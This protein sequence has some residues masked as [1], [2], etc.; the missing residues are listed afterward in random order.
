MYTLG[1]GFDDRLG[2]DNTLIL[3]ND[4]DVIFYVITWGADEETDGMRSVN[5][6]KKGKLIES[7]TASQI[8][9]CDK[10]KERCNFVYSNYDE[11]VDRKKSN[12]GTKNYKKVLKDGVDEKERFLSDFALFSFDDFVYLTDYKKRTHTFDLRDG[13]LV[14]SDSFDNVF[15]RIKT[16]GRVTKSEVASYG[17]PAFFDFPNLRNGRN[18]HTSLANHIGM[19]ASGIDERNRY[20]L[21]HV[22]VISTIAQDGTVEV[23]SIKVDDG[24]PKEEILEF[25][26]T[27]K[28][29]TSSIPKVF[30]KWHLGDQSF[31]FRKK[32]VVIARQEKRQE[33]IKERQ[34]I[35]SRLTA[36]RIKGVY[37]PANLGECFLE[38]DRQLSEID[39]KEMKA[40]PEREDMIRYHLGLGTW[41]RNNWGLWGSSRLSKYFNDRGVSHPE[42]M[43]SIILYHYHDWLNGNQDTWKQ[44][45][46]KHPRKAFR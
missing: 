46:S 16:K 36:E 7:F 30:P 13:R 44:W 3:S 23:E 41:M 10:K 22:D 2:D 43:S 38:L 42:E 29:D 11:V 1:R 6:Y 17:A 9:G 32:S 21:Y 18:V 37:I 28:F 35:Q 24:S 39:K 14:E 26:K 31:Y 15:D 33:R 19:T 12:W 5:V 25:F 34:V 27:N 40:K 4:G 8:T 20:K 45:E